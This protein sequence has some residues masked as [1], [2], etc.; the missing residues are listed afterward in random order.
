MLKCFLY[1]SYAALLVLSGCS[2]GRKTN[3][4]SMTIDDVYMATDDHD[5]GHS[6]MESL[7]QDAMVG[8]GTTT[9]VLIA[10]ELMKNSKQFVEEGM[11]PQVVIKGY[12]QALKFI[13]G[14][15]HLIF[16]L[17]H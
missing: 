5:G 13:L 8:D 14:H 2:D 7:S 6:D 4:P 15:S 11:H 16:S 1:G 12:Q 17:D 10:A 9:V 3:V